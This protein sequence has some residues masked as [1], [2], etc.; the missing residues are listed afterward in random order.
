MSLPP[1][2]DPASAS[3]VPQGTPRST[4]SGAPMVGQ[5]A[6]RQR[7]TG[8]PAL[9][10]RSGIRSF[11]AVPGMAM[12]IPVEL[13]FLG[14][15]G[16]AA[17]ASAWSEA[18]VPA[19]LAVAAL[20][21]SSLE[22]VIEARFPAWLHGCYLGFLLAGPFAGTRLGLYAFR[23]DWDKVIHVFS[24]VLVGCA[25]T[26]ALGTVGRRKHLDLPPFLMVAGVVASGGFVAAAWEIAE[27]TS[28]GLLGTHAQNASLQDTMTDIIC[29]VLGAIAVAVA[30]GIHLR[31]HPVPPVSSLL[32]NRDFTVSVP[33]QTRP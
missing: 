7:D 15:L 12:L 9:P 24:G 30:V 29:G 3:D 22:R 23:P 33:R 5:P 20:V 13:L 26:F 14:F 25:I 10:I 27:F 19:L 28:D 21:P 1:A 4:K 31:G 11:L 2:P 6:G 32:R 16:A 8:T 18:L 17:V